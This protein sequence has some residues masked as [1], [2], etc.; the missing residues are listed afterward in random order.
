M[1]SRA[2]RRDSKTTAAAHWSFHRC[3]NENLMSKVGSVD[4]AKDYMHSR[5][6]VS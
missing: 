1:C 2:T 4:L 5:A 3:G 6:E